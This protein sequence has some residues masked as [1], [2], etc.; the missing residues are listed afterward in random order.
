MTRPE[1]RADFLKGIF[2]AGSVDD[3]LRSL[4]KMIETDAYLKATGLPEASFTSPQAF[5]IL[6]MTDFGIGT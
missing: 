1:D 6:P 5:S 3:T 2:L 4:I